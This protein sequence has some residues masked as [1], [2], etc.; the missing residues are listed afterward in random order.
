MGIRDVVKKKTTRDVDET[1]PRFVGTKL[2][3]EDYNQLADALGLPHSIGG[4]EL[5]WALVEALADYLDEKRD[6]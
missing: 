6:Q 2:K 5:F 3:P 1:A 4:T